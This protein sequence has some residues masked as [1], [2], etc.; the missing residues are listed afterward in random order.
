[1]IPTQFTKMRKRRSSSLGAAPSAKSCRWA[2]CCCAVHCCSSCHRSPFKACA[3]Q[4]WP[5]VS[6]RLHAGSS[7]TVG[8]DISA[9]SAGGK[10]SVITSLVLEGTP[11]PESSTEGVL[12]SCSFLVVFIFHN[13]ACLV[14]TRD[15]LDQV[16]YLVHTRVLLDLV[17]CLVYTRVLLDQVACLV[18][19][20]VLLD[21]VA[22]LVCIR[23]LLG[24]VTCL[25]YT[26]VLLDQVTCLV[27]T[28]V[29]LDQVACL[30]HTRV[31]L[32]QVA[33]LVRTRVLLDCCR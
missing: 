29:L 18:H 14:H 31:L 21:Q 17:A 27:C 13:S 23:V 28:R 16:A 32:D 6:L 12:A 9:L 7:A 24:Q 2:R 3:I 1:M 19:T 22:C 15:V 4:C 30:V 33:C 26:R 25:V 8:C 5:L 20:R 11:P 10:A